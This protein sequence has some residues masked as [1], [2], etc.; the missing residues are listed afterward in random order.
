M[1]LICFCFSV[2]GC[3]SP[4]KDENMFHRRKEEEEE[5]EAE[6]AG[7]KR[8][9]LGWHSDRLG[10]VKRRHPSVQHGP[11]IVCVDQQLLHLG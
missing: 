7:Q 9:R 3:R 2:A 1:Q 8:D 11:R 6:S 10:W 4:E 5:E